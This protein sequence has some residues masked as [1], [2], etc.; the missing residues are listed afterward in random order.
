[1]GAQVVR[2]GLGRR[3]GREVLAAVVLHELAALIRDHERR[4]RP[5]PDDWPEEPRRPS[6]PPRRSASREP[7]VMPV[8]GVRWEDL[9]DSFGDPRPGGRR[10]RGIDI[11]APRWTEVVAA[12]YG[13]LTAIGVGGLA[14]R[15]LWLVGRDGRSFFYGHLQAWGEGI[16]EDMPVAPGEVIGYVGNSGNAARLPTH[17]HFEI[18]DQE[19]AIDPYPVLARAEP[20]DPSTRVAAGRVR[21]RRG[22]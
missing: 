3:Q 10:H 4:S 18:H 2:H 7:L 17:L 11:F 8:A 14:G 5:C 21:P 19:R 12:S 22:A 1:V 13:T 16:Y 9:R 6:A 20:I 15:S